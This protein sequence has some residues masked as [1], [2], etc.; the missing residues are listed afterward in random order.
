MTNI[1]HSFAHIFDDS[2]KNLNELQKFTEIIK[3]FIDEAYEG[4]IILD[5]K[6]VIQY[7]N[8]RHAEYLDT[9]QESVLHKHI[10][11]MASPEVVQGFMDV[12]RTEK[13]QLFRIIQ[14]GGK[15]FIAN[16]FPIKKEGKVIGAAGIVLF[17]IKE[18][19]AINK[20]ITRLENQLTYYKKALK[21]IRSSRYSFEDIIGESEP[22]KRVRQ[23]ARRAAQ[24][25]A[26]VLLIGESG[27]GKELFA[28]AIHNQSKRK[29]G[30]FVG[31]NCSAI[32]Q[33]LL[34][35][36]LFGYEPG[37]FTGAQ[38]GGKKGKFE[39]ADKGTILLD[40][41]GDMP[42]QMQSK[43]LRV[44]QEK[45]IDRIGG[46]KPVRVDFRLI[47]ATNTDLI[48]LVENGVF[49]KDLYYRLNVIK[50]EIPPLRR[51]ITDITSL[52]ESILKQKADELG[53]EEIG[54][55][56][57]GLK[58]LSK[59]RYPGNVRE[60]IN[61]LEKAINRMDID[62]SSHE[63]L[64]ISH[65]DIGAVF[66]VESPQQEYPQ[67]WSQLKEVKK[68][69]EAQMIREALRATRGNIS[70][71]AELMGI[72]RTGLHRKIK[73][74]NLHQDVRSAREPQ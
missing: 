26:H 57:S 24:K 13:P 51:R 41:I 22:I 29:L 28:H 64:S 19:D 17:D 55:S 63:T 20:K 9:P 68:N 16:R 67:K 15:E 48:E 10:S 2:I 65:E 40:E 18:V 52:T 3:I 36:E 38:R 73:Q 54:I 56:T 69:Q 1:G 30:P 25:D 37:S 4:V 60:L 58:V 34:E 14:D 61:I 21:T 35:S 50:I 42:L 12:I 32:P 66:N 74:Y 31:V 62:D 23:E 72:H 6:G 44:L 45:E 8:R 59:Y 43:L 70:K 47:A 46:T 11:K 7:T 53:L 39:L 5:E 33:E 71:C 27:T 49:R